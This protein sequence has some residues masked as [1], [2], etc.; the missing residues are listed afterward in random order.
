M[1]GRHKQ[2]E[3]A[4]PSTRWLAWAQLVTPLA[5]LVF[6]FAGWWRHYWLVP[7]TLGAVLA[8]LSLILQYRS[9]HSSGTPLPPDRPA[10]TL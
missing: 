5:I 4:L 1:S 3:S 9:A 8:L 6:I 10:R 2:P 7:V